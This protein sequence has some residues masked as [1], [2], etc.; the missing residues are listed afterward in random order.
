MRF[1]SRVVLL[2][3]GGL[4]TYIVFPESPPWLA[5]Q[6]GVTAPVARLSARG[7][8]WLH[9]GNLKELLERGQDGGANPVAAMPSLHF[10]FAVLIALFIG[11]RMRSRWRW[12]L[13]LYPVAMGFALV[14]LGEHWVL[15]LVAGLVYAVAAHLAMFRIEAWWLRRR[16]LAGPPVGPVEELVAAP[17]D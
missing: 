11:C 3:V 16:A 15:D 4:L 12:L 6:H 2:S 1:V 17:R 13:A 10:G 9:A 5:A 8:I 7:Y 14:Y